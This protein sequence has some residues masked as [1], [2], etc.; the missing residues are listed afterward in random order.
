MKRNLKYVILILCLFI[1]YACNKEKKYPYSEIYGL[2]TITYLNDSTFT[3]KEHY[4]TNK[5]KSITTFNEKGEK[6]GEYIEYYENSNIK[7]KGWYKL[8]QEIG[9]W[10]YYSSENDLTRM[11]E[12]L[13]DKHS[14]SYDVSFNEDLSFNTKKINVYSTV[15]AIQDTIYNG[16]PYIFNVRLLTPYF[17]KG[18]FVVLLDSVQEYCNLNNLSDKFENR[19]ECN[20]LEGRI[21]I[22][23]YKI[24]NNTLKGVIMNYGDDPKKLMT[25][26]FSKNFY[27]KDSYK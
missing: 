9:K 4:K 16:E 17:S 2:I 10:F 6:H 3:A 26:Y 23:K 27:V 12:Y 1:Q 8:N 5:I 13:C 25:F 22:N 7:K 21:A 24:G 15:E 11:S 18:M 19:F 20:G 14:I